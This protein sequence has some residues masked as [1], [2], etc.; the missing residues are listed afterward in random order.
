MNVHREKNSQVFI[1]PG[2]KYLVYFCEG[3]LEQENHVQDGPYVCMFCGARGTV[4]GIVVTD[5][6]L[7][8]SHVTK[9]E[10]DVLKEQKAV[11]CYVYKDTIF[12]RLLPV[13]LS[14]RLPYCKE[15]TFKIKYNRQQ[16]VALLGVKV[17]NL[18]R[19]LLE[20]CHKNSII[21]MHALTV[22]HGMSENVNGEV[23]IIP[24]LRYLTYE[25]AV[26]KLRFA[27]SIDRSSDDGT[28]LRV[29]DLT[30]QER[31][32]LKYRMPER[33]YEYDEI[34]WLRFDPFFVS[35][36]LPCC[37]ELF[38]AFHWDQ[39]NCIRLL[40]IKARKVLLRNRLLEPF[41]LAL[42]MAQQPRLGADSHLSLL[43]TGTLQTIAWLL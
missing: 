8:F 19:K 12:V 20:P 39:R 32:V 22:F 21:S 3:P 35:E 7:E 41:R 30:N 16:C 10:L 43:E 25:Q 33:S 29:S 14:V 9:E 36:R 28:R 27:Y 24:G 15:V 6:D 38:Y 26:F 37:N 5:E 31:N 42:A 17:K 11:S 4:P 18:A 1:M 34:V 2:L 13:T 23:F 40:V